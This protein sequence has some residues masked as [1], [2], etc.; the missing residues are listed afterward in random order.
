M[1]VQLQMFVTELDNCDFVLWTEHGVLSVPVKYDKIFMENAL[2]QL[3]R[4]WMHHVLP[5]LAQRLVNTDKGKKTII[6]IG[7]L[8][9]YLV[10]TSFY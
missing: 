2:V 10:H 3:E 1:Q 7:Y 5:V 4:F 9:K 6:K 8:F